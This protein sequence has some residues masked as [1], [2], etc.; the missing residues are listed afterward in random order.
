MGNKVIILLSQLQP[1]NISQVTPAATPS[2]LTAW[3]SSLCTE[4]ICSDGPMAAAII[5]KGR[6]GR[7]QRAAYND[8]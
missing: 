1:L 6:G 7:E 8:S 4:V 5:L 2:Q 3:G